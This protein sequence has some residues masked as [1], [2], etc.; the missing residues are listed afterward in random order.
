MR[1]PLAPSNS[2]LLQLAKRRNGSLNIESMRRNLI[3]ARAG[4]HIRCVACS[5]RN[6]QG[7]R[8]EFSVRETGNVETF[9]DCD[10]AYE[11]F[12]GFLHGGIIAT[13]L[14]AAMTNC[15]FAHGFVC[16]TG[17]LKVRYYHP[18][19]IGKAAHTHAWLERSAHRLHYLRAE[20]EQDGVIKAAASSKFL[21]T[22]TA[23]RRD[24]SGGAQAAGGGPQK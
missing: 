17:E 19:N 24:D 18:V 21:E 22:D 12:P 14:D 11:G 1:E 4:C 7:L 15:L 10:A 9:F 5:S 6:G 23:I 8:L 3:A 16:L 13:L 20:L 2:S